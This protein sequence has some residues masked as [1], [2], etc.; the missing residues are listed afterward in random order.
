MGASLS[1]LWPVLVIGI[2]AGI[3]IKANWRGARQEVR[4]WL[5][6]KKQPLDNVGKFEVRPHVRAVLERY[7][8]LG[9]FRGGDTQAVRR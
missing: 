3:L 5:P 6:V 1:A 9:D 7:V 8:R 2:C 4:T